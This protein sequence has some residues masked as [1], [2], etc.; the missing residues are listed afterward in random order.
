VTR[1][2]G[3]ARSPRLSGLLLC[4][5]A[6]LLGCPDDDDGPTPGPGDDSADDDDDSADDDDDSA[7]DDDV[8]D[9]GPPDFPDVI[10]VLSFSVLTGP[11]VFHGTNTNTLS[12]CLTET[13]C[14]PMNVPDVDDFRVGELDVYHV[15]GIDLPRSVVDRVAIRSVGG[16]DRWTPTCLEIRFDGEPVHCAPIGVGF[17]NEGG[18]EVE[19][20]EDPAGLHED[21][22]TCWESTRTHGPMIGAV[23]DHSVALH[24][25]ADATRQVAVWIGP[26]ESGAAGASVGAYVYPS[27]RDDFTA[28]V[29][30]GG[31]APETTYVFWIEIEGRAVGAFHEVTTGPPPGAPGPFSLAFGSCSKGAEQPIFSSIAAEE[32]DLFLFIGDNHYA[33]SDN[34]GALR[35]YYRR[36]LELPERAALAATTPT[37]ATWDDHDFTGNNTDGTEPGRDTALRA[38][39]EYWANPSV[40]LDGTPGVFFSHTRGDVDLFVLDDRYHRGLNDSMLGSGQLQ[41]L[42]DS[43]D[44]STATFK[45]IASGSQWTGEGSGDS[46]AS[47]LTERDIV[48][49]FIREQRIDGVVLLSGDVHRTELRLIDRSAAGSYSLPELVSSP[50]ANSNSGC[51]SDGELLGCWNTGNYFITVEI[52]ST[53]ADPT[54]VA[55]VFDVAGVELES[56][57]MLRSEL[58]VP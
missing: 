27:P 30:L 49:D 14:F 23:T 15:E 10:D 37:L 43:L 55:R 44:A 8:V 26:A 12:L 46:W 38:F 54:L 1:T 18:E 52:D 58:E 48:F 29:L 20:W 13:D 31:L 56:W 7:D 34:L 42:L 6:G 57:T 17:G 5:A 3:T 19:Y 24:L 51:G 53:V 28:E 45:L 16:T 41:W 21:C 11:G 50:L 25:R 47:F 9:P 2:L 4:V 22:T 32:P 35:W 40:G 39:G 36:A 33:N